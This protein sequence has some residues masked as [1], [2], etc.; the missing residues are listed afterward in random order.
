MLQNE[1]FYI[2]LS[3]WTCL[4]NI[5]LDLKMLLYHFELFLCN[6]HVFLILLNYV[7]FNAVKVIIM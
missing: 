2:D 5:K 7:V 3:F 1:V 6:C 4:Y